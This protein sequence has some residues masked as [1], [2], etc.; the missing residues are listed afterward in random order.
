MDAGPKQD[1]W[2]L[3]P[4]II[5]LL[6]GAAYFAIMET[7][8]S[9]A[10]RIRLKAAAARGEEHPDEHGRQHVHAVEQQPIARAVKHAHAR[11]ADEIFTVLMGE[12]VEPRKDWIERNARYAV[13]IDI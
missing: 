10:S 6:L 7:A 9:S 4:V 5:V 11:R 12:Q 1:L 2:N 13:N 8:F 3:L